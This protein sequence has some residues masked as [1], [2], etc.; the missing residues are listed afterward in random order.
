M[1]TQPAPSQRAPIGIVGVPLES[2]ASERG[3][4]MGPDAL[5]TAGLIECFTELGREVIDHGDIGMPRRDGTPADT[6]ALRQ[7]NLREVT[8]VVRSLADLTFS[9]AEENHIPVVLGGD[10]SL[11][12]GSIAG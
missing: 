5:R 8:A 9:I 10:H 11:A 1:T 7:R 4:R 6:A 2:G 3:A 12:M